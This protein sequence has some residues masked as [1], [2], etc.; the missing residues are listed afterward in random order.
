MRQDDACGVVEKQ[1]ERSVT[2]GGTGREERD[3]DHGRPWRLGSTPGVQA[4]GG[5]GQSLD[6]YPKTLGHH[7]KF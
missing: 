6:F 5:L 3:H 7:W 2:A 4:L 1:E